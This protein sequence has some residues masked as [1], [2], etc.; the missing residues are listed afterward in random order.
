MQQRAST[1]PTTTTARYVDRV[2]QARAALEP[3][4]G[5]VERL[6]ELQNRTQRAEAQADALRRL[7]KE[8]GVSVRT[9]GNAAV[10]GAHG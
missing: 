1:P 6:E 4:A 10:Q 5:I 2:E 8:R 3:A 9:E 7:L